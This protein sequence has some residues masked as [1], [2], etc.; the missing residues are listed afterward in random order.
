M[1]L[2]NENVIICGI[3]KDCGKTLLSNMEKVIETSDL[4]KKCKIVI[5]ENNSK[6]NT[7]ELLKLIQLNPLFRI[8][9]EDIPQD[10]IRKNSR[11]W[12]Y[13]KITGSDHPCRIEQISNARNKVLDEINKT[14]YN[15]YTYVMWIDLD[16]QGWDI[17]GIY[18]S[19]KKKNMWD[20]IYAN[21]LNQHNEFYDKYAFRDNSKLFGPEI[22]GEYFWQNLP[23]I[24]FD[25]NSKLVPV[26]SSFGGI[27]IFK[28]EI[29]KKYK[30]DCIV[31]DDM[32]K[33][34]KNIFN[35]NNDF[36]NHCNSINKNLLN[37]VSNEDSKF[38]GGEKDELL[39]I[40]W[41]ANSGYDK[42][43][44][45]EHVCFNFSLINNGYKLFINPKMIYKWG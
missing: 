21:G 19:F 2:I 35:T 27:G 13:T 36:I 30:Y 15:E 45:C 34:Y 18:D 33:F 5:Y 4:F 44:I 26:F 8:I 39:D 14:E 38:T 20:V 29:F 24:K 3:I 25:R 37:I 43:V 23:L 9:S 28:K 41:K 22:T 1:V 42:P 12:A 31:N 10:I 17:N 7:K 6:D 11:I 40:F 32:K 16:S